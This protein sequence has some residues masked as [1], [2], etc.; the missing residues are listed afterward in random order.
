MARQKE[1]GFIKALTCIELSPVFVRELRKAVAAG[2]KALEGTKPN[3][4]SA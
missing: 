3:A 1:L 2:K 4:A